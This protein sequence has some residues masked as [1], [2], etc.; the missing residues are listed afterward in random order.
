LSIGQLPL[1][2]VWAV[3]LAVDEELDVDAVDAELEVDAVAAVV[4]VVALVPVVVLVRFAD[5]DCVLA[6]V[7][8][9]PSRQAKRPP[10]E[11]MLVTLKAAAAARA[12]AARGGR[13]GRRVRRRAGVGGSMPTNLRMP[14]EGAPRAR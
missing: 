10:S 1:V 7:E 5:A 3:A 4:L 8:V 12:R 2:V 13:R 9:R 11:S 6:V 14:D